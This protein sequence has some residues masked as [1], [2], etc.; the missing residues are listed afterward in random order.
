M[1]YSFLED[2]IYLSIENIIGQLCLRQAS[3]HVQERTVHW[4]LLSDVADFLQ[5]KGKLLYNIIF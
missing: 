3:N 2:I 5:V 4:N 1:N